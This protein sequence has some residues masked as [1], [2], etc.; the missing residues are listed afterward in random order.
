MGLGVA[1]GRRYPGLVH[2]LLPALL[3]LAVPLAFSE[4]LGLVHLV[5]PDNTILLFSGEYLR[6]NPLLFLRNIL[7]FISLLTGVTGVFL[8]AGAPLGSLY[9][10]SDRLVN[11]PDMPARYHDALRQFRRYYDLPFTVNS[12]RDTAL[13]VGGGT[14]SDARAASRNHYQHVTSVDIDAQIVALGREFHP[15]HPYRD[16]RVVTVIDDA[17]AFFNRPSAEKYDIVCFGL[18]DSH[19]MSSAMSTLRLDNYVYTEEGIRAAW[20]KVGPGGHLSP[21]CRPTRGRGLSTGSTGPSPRPPAGSRRRST[22]NC[23][24]LARS[25]SRAMA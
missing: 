3:V 18:P 20:E 7:I 14:G 1:L 5:F 21:H 24:S 19:A 13:I 10:L 22:I 8:C 15:E 17:R 9:D 6:A 16:P 11:E 4:R 23:C 25:W 12:Q 2:F